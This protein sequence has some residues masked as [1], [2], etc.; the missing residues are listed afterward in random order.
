MAE[1]GGA[2]LA[3]G[4]GMAAGVDDRLASDLRA[5]RSESATP[6][7]DFLH[8]G[9]LSGDSDDDDDLGPLPHGGGRN[10]QVRRG[11]G[12]LCWDAVIPPGSSDSPLTL[13]R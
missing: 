12:F 5:A 11:A 10:V 13:W 6:L 2:A 9:A 8:G 7:E 4:F 1:F 3:G